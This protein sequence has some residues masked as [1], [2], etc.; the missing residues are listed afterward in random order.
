MTEAG[1]EAVLRRHFVAIATADYDDPRWQP[2]QLPV[3]DEVRVLWDWLGAKTLGDRRFGHLHPHLADNPTETEI[4]RALQ[5]PEA[6]LRWGES[7]AAVVYITGH[8]TVAGNTHWIV[9][10]DDATMLRTGDLIGWLAQTR[11]DYLLLIVDQCY[12]EKVS[13]D[14][15]QWDEPMRPGWLI[16]LSAARNE[17]TESGALTN[18]IAEFLRDVVAQPEE[19]KP[20]PLLHAEDFVRG[21]QKH[22]GRTLHVLGPRRSGPHPCLP[23]P[24]YAAPVESRDA[25][26]TPFGRGDLMRRLIRA[27]ADAP[28]TLLVTGRA[29]SGKSAALVRLAKMTRPRRVD[30]FVDAA[31]LSG[32]ELMARIFEALDIASPAGPGVSSSPQEW[33]DAWAHWYESQ[34]EPVTVVVDALDEAAAPD[35]LLQDLLVRLEP[36]RARRR[37]LRLIIA[38][39]SPGGPDPLAAGLALDT[40]ADHAEQLLN[41]DRVRLDEPPYW[42]PEEVA[43]TVT[44]LLLHTENSPYRGQELQAADV[45]RAVA[46]AAGSSYL[47]ACM[48]AENLATRATVV[49]PGD[50]EWETLLTEGIVGIFRDDLRRTF[51]E[52]HDRFAA[53]ELLRAV[54]YAYGRGMPRS[55]IWPVVANALSDFA[56]D[57]YGDEEIAW[58]LSSRMGAYL[59]LDDEDGEP[60]YRLFHDIL[61]STLIQRWRHLVQP[62]ADPRG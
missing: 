7:D 21:V 41:A 8:G 59:V 58:L 61:R 56:A 19:Y 49:D 47:M 27:A 54:A 53:V 5:P 12:A 44:A 23:N 38:M 16:V 14:I 36:P 62:D 40:L 18:A 39:R 31:G 15:A 51:P 28:H 1:H 2:Q 45:A 17:E 3:A 26:N 13:V 25:E 37:R 30:A 29:G 42:Q 24:A 6:Q 43:S 22:F 50:R 48:A 57:P 52:Q 20:G 33:L 10:R 32:T 55:D 46:E 9:L 11:I 4:R 35:S 60:V 34:P